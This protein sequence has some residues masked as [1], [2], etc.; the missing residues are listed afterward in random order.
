VY[1]LARVSRAG[2]R[3]ALHEPEFTMLEWYRAFSGIEAV[4]AD[5]E[6]LVTAVVERRRAPKTRKRRS[7]VAPD[8][9]SIDVSPPFRRITVREAF[10]VHAGIDDAADL[11]ATDPDRYFRTFV[12]SVEPALALE[13]SAFFLWQF[14]LTEAALARP[15]ASDPSVA[16]RFE[17]Y[18]GGVELCNGFGELTDAA[19][20]RRRFE[21]EVARRARTGAPE[22]PI[23]EAFLSALEEGMPAAGGNALGFDRLV[24]LALGASRLADVIAFPHAR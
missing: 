19:E 6:F 23:D 1:Q 24:M 15:C 22:H 7:V 13:P 8:G 18:A 12:E 14:P 16:E 2:E 9:R 10:R 4:I 5:T 3:G 11:A 17:L 20:Q 21:A